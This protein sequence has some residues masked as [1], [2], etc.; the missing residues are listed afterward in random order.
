MEETVEKRVKVV[1][2]YGSRREEAMIGLRGLEARGK[3]R[4]KGR[5]QEFTGGLDGKRK[6]Y[7]LD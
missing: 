3:R 5:K 1:S 2:L 6:E 4:E 7:S